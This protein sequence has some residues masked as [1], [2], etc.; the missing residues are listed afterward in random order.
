METLAIIL[1]SF[2]GILLFAGILALGLGN[3]RDEADISPGNIIDVWLLGGAITF[4]I[5]IGRGFKMALIDRSHPTFPAFVILLVG[6][7]LVIA[8]LIM[9]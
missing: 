8:G 3:C 7:S 2:G 4:L 9:L 5:G 6:L 1:L